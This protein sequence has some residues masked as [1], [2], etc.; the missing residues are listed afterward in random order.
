M[1][2]LR[3][4]LTFGIAALA[5]GVLA[6]PSLLA[7]ATTTTGPTITAKPSHVMVSTA[8]ALAGTGF[9]ADSRLQLRECGRR[10]WLAPK[11]PCNTSN[12]ITVETNRNGRFRATFHVE[13]CPEGSAGKMPTERICYIGRVQLGEDTGGLQPAARIIV[14][15]P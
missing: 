11:E 8:T 7:Q 12:A 1:T 14:T 10:F 9:P 4:R 5:I 13:L 2:A 15:Y 3:T 6:A